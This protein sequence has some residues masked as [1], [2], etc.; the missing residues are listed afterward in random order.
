MYD[1]SLEIRNGELQQTFAEKVSNNSGWH[2][3][4]SAIA[5][6]Y[7]RDRTKGLVL[8]LDRIYERIGID[9]F[10]NDTAYSDICE[11]YRYFQQYKDADSD[12]CLITFDRVS[13][14]LDF[15]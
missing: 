15:I 14:S 1:I 2:R 9:F 5:D 12:H 13:E 8:S 10:E 11:I 6:L 7:F 4:L 3:T